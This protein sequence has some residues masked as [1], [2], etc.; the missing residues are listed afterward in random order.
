MPGGVILAAR[1]PV[2]AEQLAQKTLATAPLEAGAGRAHPPFRGWKQ[3]PN[4][5]EGAIFGGTVIA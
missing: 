1:Y 2:R 5:L 4:A 3:A